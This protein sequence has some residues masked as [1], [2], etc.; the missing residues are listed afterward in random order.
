MADTPT[1]QDVAHLLFQLAPRLTRLENL[2]L[3]DLPVAL[4]FRQYRLLLRVSEGASTLTELRAPST[5]TLSAVSESVDGLVQ[6]GMLGRVADPRDRRAVTISL[7]E[8]GRRALGE[9]QEILDRLS[10]DLFAD[11][12]GGDLA[13]LALTLGAVTDRVTERLQS[14]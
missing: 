6:R 14:G 10:G 5:L 9:A 4:T 2:L 12:P 1:G 7:T 8:P 3:K 11:L 13:G